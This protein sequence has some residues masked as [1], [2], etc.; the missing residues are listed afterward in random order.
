[1]EVGREEESRLRPVILLK[2]S[3]LRGSSKREMGSVKDDPF[4]SLPSLIL[5]NS[6]NKPLTV[7]QDPDSVCTL[8]AA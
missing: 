3:A 7:L 1:M 5:Y 2:A 6:K 4:K 8:I